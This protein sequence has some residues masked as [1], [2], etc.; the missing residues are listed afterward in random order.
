V[1]VV[2][3]ADAAGGGTPAPGVPSLL[4]SINQRSVLELIRRHGPLSRAQVARVSGL[5]KPTV[6]Q[7][8]SQ[9]TRADLVRQVGRSRGA[10]GPSALLYE[11]NARAGWVVGIDVGRRWL[12]AAVADL[13]GEVLARRDERARV[14]SAATL[15]AQVGEAARTV[16][17]QAGLR[18]NQVT[19]ATVGSP[20]VFDPEQGL[21]AM[22]PNLPGWG[23][24][25][26]VEALREELGI[27]V[28]FENDVNLAA[29]GEQARGLGQ[30]VRDFVYL[31]VGTG[32]GLGLVLNGQLYR[33]S[34]GAAGEIAYLPIG[35]ADPHDPA[36]RRRG[37]YEETAAGASIVR[38]AKEAGMGPPLNAER[39]F[40]A[41]R[42]GVPAATAA[43][44]A[45]AANLALGI[46]AVAAV[47]DP[48]LVI[49]G[50]GV[51][52]SG[53]LLVPALEEE[54]RR[55]SPFHPRVAVS[56]LGDDAVLL[57]AV[58][59][60]LGAARRRLFARSRQ[61]KESIG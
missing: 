20:G 34:R 32:V 50:G 22:A 47:V 24:H 27:T 15:V 51:G 9:L 41:A 1:D 40:A 2:D 42:R 59:T 21:V 43:V 10:K 17:R 58:A 6:S 8:L 4:R 25:G 46:A 38:L 49:L 35:P 16:A 56:T 18:W 26:L 13:S 48:E 23:R 7:V 12:R 61:V 39:V 60:A 57:G 36:V 53:D 5:S 29:L 14:R 54:L 3:I 19:Q 45:E 44:R 11:L 37:L 30:G 28:T 52:R 31:W 33:G 55:L